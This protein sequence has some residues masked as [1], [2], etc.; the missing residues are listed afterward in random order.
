M[1][2]RH[3]VAFGALVL[4]VFVAGTQG[5]PAVDKGQLPANNIAPHATDPA[6]RA[7]VLLHR[8]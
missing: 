6:A 2:L 1:R 5:R 4:V 7:T 3:S 8:C